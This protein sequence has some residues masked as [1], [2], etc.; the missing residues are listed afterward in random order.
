MNEF[1]VRK[2]SEVVYGDEEVVSKYRMLRPHS[3]T[4]ALLTCSQVSAQV[5][6][7]SVQPSGMEAAAPNCRTRCPSI[8]KGLHL[9][10]AAIH[11]QFYSRD[12]SDARD[13]GLGDLIGCVPNLP[14]GTVLEISF[15]C[16][17]PTSEEGSR[18]STQVCRWSPGS[19]RSRECG[20]LLISCPC[21]HER[22]HG[23]LC[24]AING[25]PRKSLAGD[26]GR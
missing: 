8:I 12:S 14:S 9:S 7:P 19:P 4:T 26:D 17:S 10:D 11:E 6:H 23:G 5:T 21:P 13:H 25:I 18:Y 16:C 22:T 1:S 3:G 15:F 24:G 20:V 2:L